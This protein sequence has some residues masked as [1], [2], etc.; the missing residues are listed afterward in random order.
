MS[1]SHQQSGGIGCF[2]V[3]GIVLVVLKAL[4]I[5]PVA[6]WSWWLVTAP[7]WAPLVMTL[8]FLAGVMGIAKLKGY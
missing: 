7:F 3:I 6:N 5:Q 8:V 4:D 2:S 1:A